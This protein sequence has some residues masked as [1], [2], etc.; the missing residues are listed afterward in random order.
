MADQVEAA[1]RN[2]TGKW[3]R[4]DENGAMLKGWV[5]IE[6]TLAE[7]YPDQRGN[8]YYYDQ[9]TGLMAKGWTRINGVDYYFDEITGVLQK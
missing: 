8:V 2:H 5:T 4:Y 7:C 6:G 1:I 9:K 3:V